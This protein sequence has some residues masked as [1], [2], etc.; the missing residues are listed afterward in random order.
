MIFRLI[1][2]AVAGFALY[3]RFAPSDASRWHVDPFDHPSGRD[4]GSY[5]HNQSENAD[6]GF[7]LSD[8]DLMARVDAVVMATPRTV[9]LAGSVEDG[10]VTYV[11]RSKLWGFPDYTS[12]AVR[13]V[14]DKAQLAIYGRLRFGKSDMGV[15]QARIQSWLLALM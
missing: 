14:G 5:T 7:D 1:I 6:L 13:M 4:A 2:L 3:V 15:N 8:A 12:V 11:T 9:R 10:H